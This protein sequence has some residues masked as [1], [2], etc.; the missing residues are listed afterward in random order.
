MTSTGR[1][2]V[3][4]MLIVNALASFGAV[5]L[6]FAFAQDQAGD[7]SIEEWMNA[8]MNNVRVLK[9]TLHLSRFA[10]PVYVLTQPI[11]WK[12]NADQERDFQAVTV[13]EGFVTDF[14]SIP[15]IFWSLLR[16]DGLY[17]YPAIVHDFLYW[18]QTRPRQTADDIFRFGMED[19]RI[20]RPII[21]AIYQAVSIAGGFAWN[22]NAR[23]KTA[24]EKRVLRRY[25]DDPQTRW[26]DWQK[27]PDVFV[28]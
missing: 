20:A 18:T 25:P 1:R 11:T 17:T 4:A 19:M 12:P 26:A 6:R 16:P 23:A 5:R 27:L 7:R 8:W 21:E 14:A 2:D 10:E 28:E 15:R 24:G 22:A 13:P 3:L 9:G